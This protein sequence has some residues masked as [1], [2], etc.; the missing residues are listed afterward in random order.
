M[1]EA[2]V[3]QIQP[4]DEIKKIWVRVSLH[5]TDGAAHDNASLELFIE[6]TDSYEEIRNRAIAKAQAFLAKGALEVKGETK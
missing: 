5:E 4:R 3:Q 1:I 2:K 6:P